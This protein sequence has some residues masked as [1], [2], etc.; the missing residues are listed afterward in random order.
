MLAW[1]DVFDRYV[2][3]ASDEQVPGITIVAESLGL[4]DAGT[5]ADL[6]ESAAEPGADV[7]VDYTSITLVGDGAASETDSD[8]AIE[9]E[10]P[11]VDADG[12]IDTIVT[13]QLSIMTDGTI[14]VAG[15]VEDY[16]GDANGNW[17]AS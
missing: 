6:D 9:I 12:K 2:G 3:S 8:N 4:D 1:K 13:V 5:Q 7:S 10:L 14:G 11:S 16:M 17:I 15:E